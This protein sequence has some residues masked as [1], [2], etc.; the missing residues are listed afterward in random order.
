MKVLILMLAALS[1]SAGDL[2]I[3]FP[4]GRAGWTA[5]YIHWIHLT[6]DGKDIGKIRN[7][8]KVTIHLPDGKHF[9]RANRD[10]EF[11]T[12]I[13]VKGNHIL[14]IMDGSGLPWT[15]VLESDPMAKAEIYNCEKVEKLEI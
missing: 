8:Q 7:W 5:G 13:E 12:T 11:A 6:I 10:M 9:I 15:E 14:R 3:Y 1:L 2:T 4:R